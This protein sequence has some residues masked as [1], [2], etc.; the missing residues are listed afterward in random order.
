MD[1]TLIHGHRPLTGFLSNIIDTSIVD[2]FP[3]VHSHSL[4]DQTEA[5][6]IGF[7]RVEFCC[8]GCG[9]SLLASVDSLSDKE[10]LDERGKFLSEHALC[11]DFGFLDWCPDVRTFSMFIDLRQKVATRKHPVKTALISKTG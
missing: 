9:S 2:R 1:D 3:Q 7:L 6:L 10:L 8:H 5:A 11:P 4:T